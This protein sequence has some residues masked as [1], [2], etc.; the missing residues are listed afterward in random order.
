MDH[1]IAPELMILWGAGHPVRS[2]TFLL[3]V[4]N[5]HRPTQGHSVDCPRPSSLVLPHVM[6]LW[7]LH[8]RAAHVLHLGRPR[9]LEHG[10]GSHRLG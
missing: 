8:H 7:T 2:L 9:M 4:S 10:M 1:P 5:A 6:V 3:E